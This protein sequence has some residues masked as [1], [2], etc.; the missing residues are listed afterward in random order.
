MYVG[1]MHAGSDSMFQRHLRLPGEAF[2]IAAVLMT[3]RTGLIA[4]NFTG[5]QKLG[6]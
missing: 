6:T 2:Q 1:Q 5:A 3:P 4:F